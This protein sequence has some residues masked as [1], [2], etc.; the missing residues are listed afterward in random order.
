L[1]DGLEFV[2]GAEVSCSGG[3]VCGEVERLIADPRARTVTHLVVRVKH[4]RILDRLV[5]VGLVEAAEGGSG[6]RLGCSV[7]DFRT[8]DPAEEKH[9]VTDGSSFGYFV[10]H[11]AGPGPAVIP[12]LGRPEVVTEE[13]VPFGEVDVHGGD[14][15]RASDGEVGHVEGLVIDPGDHAVTHV[16][17]E[18]GHLPLGHKHVAIPI[19]TVAMVAAGLE[20]D[21]TKQQVH[22]LPSAGMTVPNEKG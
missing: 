1:A 21:L 16:L 18:V 4:R 11:G 2:I 3:A 9:R 19:E 12:V 17:L 10:G 8:L 13:T 5:P 7:D 20:V 6:V 14:T 15:V 22:D